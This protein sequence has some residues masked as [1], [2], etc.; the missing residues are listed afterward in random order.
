MITELKLIFLVSIIYY[1]IY[2]FKLFK[3]VDSNLKNQGEIVLFGSKVLIV[4]WI[5]YG[6][7]QLYKK[8]SVIE[9]MYDGDECPSNPEEMAEKMKEIEKKDYG[10]KSNYIYNLLNYLKK[11]PHMLNEY[12]IYPPSTSCNSMF[13]E[14]I[15]QDID[16]QIKFL[17]EFLRCIKLRIATLYDNDN[18]ENVSGKGKN[19]CLISY[20]NKN[21]SRFQENKKVDVSKIIRE[22]MKD[23]NYYQMIKD[24]NGNID[25]ILVAAD[26]DEIKSLLNTI[27][28]HDNSIET[29]TQNEKTIL[30]K[31]HAKMDNL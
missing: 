19:T 24:L 22:T 4:I 1:S 6:T 31:I 9:G 10:N 20:I 26:N 3:I 30:E 13:T 11:C 29:L 12:T 23:D 25:M 18:C 21:F 27:I 14:N 5:L 2:H 17:F 28:I 16:G 7:I 15:P 8:N